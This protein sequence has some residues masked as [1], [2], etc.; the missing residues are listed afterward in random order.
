MRSNLLK[1]LFFCCYITS[2]GFV[3]ST[4][5]IHHSHPQLNPEYICVSFVTNTKAQVWCWQYPNHNSCGFY[6][7]SSF[8]RFF[9]RNIFY[10]FFYRYCFCKAAV[11][12]CGWFG[13][14]KP[15]MEIKHWGNQANDFFRIFIT[16]LKCY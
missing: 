3:A 1:L 7:S 10:L 16:F 12:N 13:K 14:L 11:N 15:L 6:L 8:S 2:G 5:N 9:F 4:C